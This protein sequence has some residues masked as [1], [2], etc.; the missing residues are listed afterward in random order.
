L[1]LDFEKNDK[2]KA[3]YYLDGQLDFSQ[4]RILR[5]DFFNPGTVSGVGISVT[6]GPDAV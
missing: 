3:I 1:Q 6:T 2:P 4:A 5:F